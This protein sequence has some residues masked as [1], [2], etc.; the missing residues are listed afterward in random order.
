MTTD[1]TNYT[2]LRKK[3]DKLCKDGPAWFDAANAVLRSYHSNEQTL[4]GAIMVGL[5]TAH[6]L[7]VAGEQPKEEPSMYRARRGIAKPEEVEEPVKTRISR[8]RV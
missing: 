6:A 1:R 2:L 8:R 4:L 5:M 7:G 3:L